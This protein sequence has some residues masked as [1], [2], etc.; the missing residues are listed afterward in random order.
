M[1]THLYAVNESAS[2]SR[3]KIIIESVATLNSEKPSGIYLFN[4]FMMEVSII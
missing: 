3:I 4:S 1:F 2:L